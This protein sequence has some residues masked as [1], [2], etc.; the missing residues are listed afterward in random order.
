[1]TRRRWGRT[2]LIGLALLALG[3]LGWLA[4]VGAF[5]RDIYHDVP[6]GGPAA[7]GRPAVAALFFSGDLGFRIGVGPGVA[8]RLAAEG[9]PVT[10]VNSL[11]YFRQRRSP[12]EIRA[13][14]E[15]SMA[16][17]RARTGARRL[18]LIGQSFGADMLHVG[19]SLMPPEEKRDVILVAFV[20]PTD[21]IFYQISLSEMMEWGVP[22]AQAVETG[23]RL[24]WVPA[25]CIQGQEEAHS[26][27]PLL[28]QPNM[29]RIALPGGHPLHHDPGPVADVLV[30]AIRTAEAPFAGGHPEN[31]MLHPM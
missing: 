15:R 26:L 29:R 16:R 9:I 21:T 11:A 30:Q 5:D 1:M 12:A 19:L 13:L 4:F 8:D 22:D 20:V 17:V 31:P 2:V 28:K 18:V 3:L 23:S 6:A 7:H 24:D 14:I 10:G 27:C 25:L